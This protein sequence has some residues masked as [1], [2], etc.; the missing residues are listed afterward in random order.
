M[1]FVPIVVALMMFAFLA[2]RTI[3][4]YK[5]KVSVGYEFKEG[6]I[7]WSVPMTCI[8]ATVCWIAG[9]FAGLFGVGGGL[10]KGPQMLEMGLLPEVAA[11]TTAF[12]IMFTSASATISF[13]A[14]ELVA[15]DYAAVLFVVGIVCTL[16]GQLAFEQ[17]TTRYM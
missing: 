5:L 14:L 11:A 3:K 13:A 17:L 1:E 15:W 4:E 10:V 2:H 8:A 9:L 16:L 12:M 6:D 7:L